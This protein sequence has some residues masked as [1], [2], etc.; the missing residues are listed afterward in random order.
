LLS[1]HNHRLYSKV[2]ICSCALQYTIL[3]L[4]GYQLTID[5][6]KQF[7]Q[8][9]S[10]TPGHPEAGHT[11]GAHNDQHAVVVL[12]NRC[13]GIEVTTGPLGQGFSNAVGLAMAQAHLGAVFNKDGFD[14]VNNYTYGEICCLILSV[15]D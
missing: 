9:G 6:L 3:H 10:K 1:F 15:S 14:L 2:N 11:D 12:S 13:S 5:D 8:L 7:R 4:L